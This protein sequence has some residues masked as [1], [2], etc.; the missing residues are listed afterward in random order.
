MF[1]NG[2]IKTRHKAS[3]V[4]VYVDPAWRGKGVAGTLIDHTVQ[5]AQAMAGVTHLTLH[6]STSNRDAVRLYQ[7]RGFEMIGTEPCAIRIDDV[8]Y[9]QHSMQRLVVRASD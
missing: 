6:V 9:D 7:S 2:G 3:I 5:R 1:R 4:S 8:C